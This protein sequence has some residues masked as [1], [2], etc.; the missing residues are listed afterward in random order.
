MGGGGR[1]C[2]VVGA[3]RRL[4]ALMI[5]LTGGGKGSSEKAEVRRW[6]CLIR[7]ISRQDDW[8]MAGGAAII[9]AII[10][11]RRAPPPPS[12]HLRTVTSARQEQLLERKKTT[13][14]MGHAEKV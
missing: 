8:A 6:G 13:V 3:C 4:V 9:A 7:C 1:R 5:E 12:T 14:M 11:R 10:L 2:S